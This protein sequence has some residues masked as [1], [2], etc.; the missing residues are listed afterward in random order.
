MNPMFDTFINNLI[1]V[2]SMDLVLIGSDYLRLML[3]HS[4][5]T[6]FVWNDGKLIRF[7]RV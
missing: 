2:M 5:T 1:T 7:L 6:C 4:T 3:N